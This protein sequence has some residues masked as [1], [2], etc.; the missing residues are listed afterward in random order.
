MKSPNH[1]EWD[2]EKIVFKK[3]MKNNKPL[4]GT[5]PLCFEDSLSHVS[6]TFIVDQASISLPKA[7]DA[8]YKPTEEVEKKNGRLAF[9]LKAVRH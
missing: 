8:Q 2:T 6:D 7:I 3:K 5:D 4:N 1:G 9:I